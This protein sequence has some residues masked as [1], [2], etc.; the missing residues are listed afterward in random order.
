MHRISRLFKQ[1][2]NALG[3]PFG[4]STTRAEEAAAVVAAA[5]AVVAAAAAP[6][7]VLAHAY[8]LRGRAD[9]ASEDGSQSRSFG[10]TK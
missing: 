10:V 5:A 6:L 8:K 1:S 3:F 7:A 2:N 9:R 4:R